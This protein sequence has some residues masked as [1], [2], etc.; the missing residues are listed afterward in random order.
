MPR[1]LATRANVL[2]RLRERGS[3]ARS[4]AIASLLVH[5]FC[6]QPL[7]YMTKL[8]SLL[9][10]KCCVVERMHSVHASEHAR[11]QVFDASRPR[12]DCT[13]MKHDRAHAH[14]TSARSTRRQGSQPT[15][16]ANCTSYHT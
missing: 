10:S 3:A 12:D 11:S 13:M 1:C 5:K 8:D 6:F 16:P 15:P 7:H 2:P 4:S 9:A 14:V